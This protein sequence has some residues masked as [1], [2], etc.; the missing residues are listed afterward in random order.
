MSFPR[1]PVTVNKDGP[2]EVASPNAKAC[3][4]R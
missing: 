2:A 4:Y 3:V 1:N